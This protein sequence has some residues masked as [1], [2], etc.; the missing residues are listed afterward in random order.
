MEQCAKHRSSFNNEQKM[1]GVLKTAHSAA[2]KSSHEERARVSSE[3]LRKRRYEE[4]KTHF[5][6]NKEKSKDGNVKNDT[7]TAATTQKK[8]GLPALKKTKIAHGDVHKGSTTTTTPQRKPPPIITRAEKIAQIQ[9]QLK[10][11]SDALGAVRTTTSDAN[12]DKCTR[13]TH[14]R[15]NL[16]KKLA[17]TTA[18]IA[19]TEQQIKDTIRTIITAN[20]PPGLDI[21]LLTP[22]LASGTAIEDV[23]LYMERLGI[24]VKTLEAADQLSDV[25]TNYRKIA[26]EIHPDLVVDEEKKKESEEA[27]KQLGHAKAFFEKL[28]DLAS[29]TTNKKFI[30]GRMISAIRS[31]EALA[32]KRRLLINTASCTKKDIDATER[33]IASLST[34][35]N[36]SRTK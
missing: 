30:M 28:F 21:K 3:V 14:K 32:N 10:F 6:E 17:I 36:Q 4:M 12:V 16:A 18:D 26:K 35:T 8:K 13:L 31:T 2:A 22:L 29:K 34:Q 15:Q 33:A 1:S 27:F 9:E 11:L 19:S 25:M 7:T 23:H 5:N 20:L 24:T